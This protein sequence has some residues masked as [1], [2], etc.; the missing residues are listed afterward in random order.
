MTEMVYAKVQKCLYIFICMTEM[1]YAKVQKWCMLK[2]I[3]VLGSQE[4]KT[5]LYLDTQP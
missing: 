2:Y 5:I 3:L 4:N 1:V